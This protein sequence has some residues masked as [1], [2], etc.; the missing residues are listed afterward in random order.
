MS[1]NGARKSGFAV[2]VPKTGVTPAAMVS[3]IRLNYGVHESPMAHSAASTPRS[4]RESSV[5]SSTP[6]AI[7]F[8]KEPKAGA[9][10]Q[11]ASRK[12]RM[13]E[14]PPLLS[15]RDDNPFI[16]D[17]LDSSAATSTTS[18]MPTSKKRKIEIYLYQAAHRPRIANSPVFSSAGHDMPFTPSVVEP[19]VEDQTDPGP[20]LMTPYKKARTTLRVSCGSGSG[21][22]S[23]ST[24]PA[25]VPIKLRSCMNMEAF[26]S[27]ILSVSGHLDQ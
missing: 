8:S 11:Q 20:P 21:S 13:S 18:A 5:V 24:S 27:S 14:S 4:R 19:S 1:R 7:L 2:V 15:T 23:G 12:H 3:P 17:V 26:F 25:W 22:G 16:P 9:Y 10:P 6:S